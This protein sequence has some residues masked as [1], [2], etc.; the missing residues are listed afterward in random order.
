MLLDALDFL[1]TDCYKSIFW[2]EHA[3]LIASITDKSEQIRK[4][5]EHYPETAEQLSVEAIK[6]AVGSD[7][8][9]AK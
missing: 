9:N 1:V 4:I 3:S 7:T 6:I 5:Q 8:F 2:A